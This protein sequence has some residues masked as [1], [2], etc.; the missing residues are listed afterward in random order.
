MK[1]VLNFFLGQKSK[2]THTGLP[3]HIAVPYRVRLKTDMATNTDGLKSEL[4]KIKTSHDKLVNCVG[5]FD[6]RIEKV[7][8]LTHSIPGL[9]Q[10]VNYKSPENSNN[11]KEIGNRIT[12]NRDSIV[13]LQDSIKQMRKRKG[14]VV[15]ISC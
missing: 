11:L 13:E 15:C 2:K 12:H 4:K 9:V 5:T 1:R 7:E 3:S 14:R 8:K 6:A 10:A